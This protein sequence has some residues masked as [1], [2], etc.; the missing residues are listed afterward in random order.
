MADATPEQMAILDAIDAS[1]NIQINALA[2]TGKTSTLEMIQ[3]WVGG[4]ILCLAFNK[5]IAKEMEDRFESTTTVRTIN[6]L[7]HR[8]WAN[9]CTGKVVLNKRKSAEILRE[10][11][12]KLGKEDREEAWEVFWEMVATVGLAK[13]LGYVP[14]GRNSKR[15]IGPEFWERVDG[16]P[17]ALFRSLVDNTLLISIKLS[18]SGNI[19]HDDQVYMPALFGGAFPNF[20][21]V[22]VDEAQDLSPINHE[23]LRKLRR[24]RLASVGDPFQS[25]Y[26]FR[27]ACQDGMAK[28]A[29]TFSMKELPLSVSWRCPSEIVKNARWRAPDLKWAKVGGHVETL[30]QLTLDGIPN[31]CAIICRNNAPLFRLAILLL[32]HGRSVRVAGS[33]IGPK[34]AAIMRRFGDNNLPRSS[35]L[36]AIDDW[37]A[38][39]IES[40]SSTAKDLA[41]CMR[42]F[43]NRGTDLGQAIAGAE[44]ILRQEGSITLTTGHKAKGLEWDIVYH[45]DPW[46]IGQGEQEWNLRYVIQTRAKEAY[47]E[48]RSEAITT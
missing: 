33:D 1:G 7:G 43:A 40:G 24:S 14:E 31:S 46:L 44:D 16:K 18:Y 4:P 21:L 36:R 27:G 26:Q 34:L 2:G 20:P 29:R 35:V 42:L 39:K 6:G 5:S 11:I 23:M 28:L 22:L 8:I 25:I 47:Y 32:S 17:T 10:E 48:I 12:K 13:S 19:D 15:L 9:A 37:T 3:E 38:R 45:L 30:A 41:E